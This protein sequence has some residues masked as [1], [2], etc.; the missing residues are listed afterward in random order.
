M[1]IQGVICREESL[2][3]SLLLR[4]SLVAVLV[5][6]MIGFAFLRPGFCQ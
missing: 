3:A 5:T 2:C 4:S 6:A 1:R